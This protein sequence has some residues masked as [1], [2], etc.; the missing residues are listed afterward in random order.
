MSFATPPSFVDACSYL[1]RYLVRMAYS[2]PAHYVRPAKQLLAVGDDVAEFATVKI[3]AGP[4]AE[5]GTSAIKWTDDPTPQSTLIIEKVDDIYR[6]TAS[7]QFFRHAIPVDSAHLPTFAMSAV[8]R[9]S[10]LCSR[11]GSSTMLD[12]METVGL[13]LEGAGQVVDVGDLVN[14]SKWEDR[15]SVDLHFVVANYETFTHQSFASA[16]FI[17]EYQ[18]E[19]ATSLQTKTIEVIP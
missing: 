18:A 15:G 12:L 13:G 11:L 10:R 19:G 7:V 1:V 2:L 16:S 3:I 5:F 4:S 8:D 17:A 9:A 6:F 14:G